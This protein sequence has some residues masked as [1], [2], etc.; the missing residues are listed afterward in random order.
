MWV[1]KCKLLTSVSIIQQEGETTDL[2]QA[3]PKK[4]MS[5]A[6][7]QQIQYVS[8]DTKPYW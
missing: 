2:A 6:E 4:K 8:K 7:H 5:K 3:G 1:Y